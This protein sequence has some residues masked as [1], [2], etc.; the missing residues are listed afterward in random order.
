LIGL[1]MQYD[2]PPS[3]GL[4]R[5][6]TRGHQTPS[7]APVY[8]SRT[9][10]TCGPVRSTAFFVYCSPFRRVSTAMD[11]VSFGLA[12]AGIPGIFVS[13]V[14]CFQ[15]VRLGLAFGV[16]FG[17]S[18]ARLQAAEVEFTRWGAAMGLLVT[19]FDPDALF[20]NGGPWKEE[21]IEM[22]KAWLAM[23]E[24]AFDDA[25]KASEK[26]SKSFGPREKPEALEVADETAELERAEKP[27]K[28]V[29]LSL[30]KVT[31]RRQQM[32]SFGRKIQWA[33]YR[34][35]DFESLIE[36]IGRLVDNLVKLFPPLQ[37]QQKQFCKEE[38]KDIE[39]ECFSTLVK[40][41]GK[42][43]ELLNRAI[44]EEIKEKGHRL[45]DVVVEGSGFTR[46]G[47]TWENVPNAKP[48]AMSASGL[49][50]RGT[51]VTH[52]GHRITTS[53]R[54]EGSAWDPQQQEKKP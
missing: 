38:L 23:I 51:G 47:D 54:E 41:L 31:K 19:P 37:N 10:R 44:G 30:R 48:T 34:K 8:E 53:V 45:V 36:T 33:L 39:P 7:S 17:F 50:I 32:L 20:K 3:G 21:E 11:P 18:L 42:N 12:V 6:A 26:F 13:C 52:F 22:A 1:G 28:K 35:S 27:V 24:D 16:D 49:H 4:L 15:Y 43:D 5:S 29:V 9:K 2:V 40:V 46:I 14:S 25:K